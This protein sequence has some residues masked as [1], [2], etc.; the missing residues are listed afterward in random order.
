MIHCSKCDS[1]LNDNLSKTIRHVHNSPMLPSFFHSA[2]TREVDDSIF[3]FFFFFSEWSYSAGKLLVRWFTR[4]FVTDHGDGVT[5]LL[6]D[7]MMCSKVSPI[8]HLKELRPQSTIET[9]VVNQC[10]T[11][12]SRLFFLGTY[13][14]K[15]VVS[16]VI[17]HWATA[18]FTGQTPELRVMGF[19]HGW[20]EAITK[21]FHC[22]DST[23][24]TCYLSINSWQ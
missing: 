16:V 10:Y 13:W 12:D 2:Q 24:C 22:A 17:S 8:C 5:I 4:D 3:N 1:A 21:P 7:H 18:A 15:L 20:F 6:K 19:S 23:W 9:A 11:E 14:T